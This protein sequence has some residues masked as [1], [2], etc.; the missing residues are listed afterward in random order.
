MPNGHKNVFDMGGFLNSQGLRFISKQPGQSA[1][2]ED[3][4]TGEQSQLDA[5]MLLNS[6][7]TNSNE[8]KIV[9]NSPENPVNISPLT[10]EDRAKVK[11]LGNARGSVRFLSQKF[12]AVMPHEE[13]GLLVMQD[14]IWHK[15]D[16]TGLGDGDP[17]E[18]AKEL[19][20]DVA[21]L[22]DVGINIAVTAPAVALGIATA[23]P[24]GGIKA[25]GA[26]G[27][28]SGKIRTSLG[29]YVGTYE[30]TPL[31]EVADIALESVLTLGG[32]LLTPGARPTLKSL[33]KGSSNLAKKAIKEPVIALYGRFSGVGEGAMRELIE[34]GARVSRSMKTAIREAGG[35]QADVTAAINV[36]KDKAIKKAT[37]LLEMSVEE[38]PKKW[39]K[40]FDE[41]FEAAEKA[42]L[43]VN[44][45]EVAEVAYKNVE[46][47][48]LGKI[49]SKEG[50][51]VFRP[52]TQAE[53]ITRIRSNLPAEQLV[54]GAEKQI[55][56]A[57]D[58][59][60]A[61]RK[62]GTV[63]GG[64]AADRLVTLNTQL[65]RL[66][67]KLFKGQSAS[68]EYKRAVASMSTGFRNALKKE[69]RKVGLEGKYTQ[70][71]SLYG[72]FADDVAEARK[73]L[74]RT[75]GPESF[76]NRLMS[77][78]AA[79]RTQAGIA[80]SLIELTGKRGQ[81][82]FRNMAENT[83]A[84]KFLP[85]A[86]KM[87]LIQVGAGVAGIGTLATGGLTLGGGAAL[88]QLSPR[89]I[90]AE[91]SLMRNLGNSLN[92]IKQAGGNAVAN[93]PA[94]FQALMRTAITEV[95]QESQLT[96]DLLQQA[97]IVGNNGEA[98]Q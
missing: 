64:I 17:W 50:D 91:A 77:D 36:D 98:G 74:D 67:R 53:Q 72:R 35:S 32:Q 66:Q 29:R 6:L 68:P 24:V 41:T 5:E 94:I 57:V 70:M 89:V 26:G 51:R 59:M 54:P 60:E 38:L 78:T 80:K 45:D 25:A 22:T 76:V 7:G 69:F 23:G 4:A 79:N 46:E 73:M 96:Q 30:A 18:M 3:M 37:D 84:S 75:G 39:G 71:Q 20:K 8:T 52:L 93:N 31:E 16:P 34:N 19:V 88:A 90:A 43:S 95:G 40:L 42:K 82:L 10:V 14:G 9:F 58:T 87:G 2:V 47:L 27:A 33:A 48:G 11:G 62:A 92:F 44:M 49:V 81:V 97:G 55:Q 21:D 61:F 1:L 15:V 63:K 12:E 65:N 28:I 85:W 83:A 56:L 86:P 13:Q